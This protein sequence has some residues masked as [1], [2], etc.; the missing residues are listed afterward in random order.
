MEKDTICSL[1][2]PYGISGIGIIRLSGPETFSI[3]KKIFKPARRKTEK[4]WK[5]HTVRYG[6]IVDGK[7][8]VIDEVLVTIMKA[9]SSYTRE[10]MAEIGC[11]GGLAAINAV[12]SVC[13][14]NGA[15]L[16][17]P[18]EFTKRAFI[19]GRIDLA[20]AESVLDIV[21]AKTEK[22]L[23]I[24]IKQL[25]GS[26]SK[27]VSD[28]R[29]RL[30]EI[31]TILNYEIDFSDDYGNLQ[32][33]NLLENINSVI[34]EIKKTLKEGSSGTIFTQGIKIAIAGKPNVGKSS[35][36]NLLV[37][38][39]KAIVSD[40]PGTTR[41]SIETTISIQGFPFTVVDTAGIREHAN[42][43]EKLGIERALKWIEKAEMVLVILDVSSG[44]DNL[45]KRIIEKTK[46]KPFIIVLNKC[47][48]PSKIDENKIR[49]ICKDAKIVRMCCINGQGIEKLNEAIIEKMKEGL[50][51]IKEPEFF[52]NIRQKNSLE[53][54]LK[55]LDEAREI[56]SSH[57]TIDIIA[58]M[59]RLAMVKIDEISGKSIS[60]E[61]LDEIFNRFCIGK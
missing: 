48:L 40:I 20:Q 32:E 12:L 41:D 61:V 45:D 30:L 51:E 10:D 42:E 27:K 52:L 60:E 50:C 43:I 21:N 58:E 38:E 24:S 3:I 47:D 13:V 4:K 16:A 23:E 33:N 18:G 53:Q 31:L 6:F 5:T 44:F 2:T 14:Q 55:I 49:A 36:L 57:S 29:N 25:R 15:R 59:I 19:N 7:G 17:Q 9:P 11:H 22:S 26:L 46:T 39:E 1:S 34:E 28:I 56:I 54:A 35:L 8:K 37:K